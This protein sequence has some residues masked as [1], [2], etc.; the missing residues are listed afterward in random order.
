M[1]RLFPKS[2]ERCG[3][4]WPWNC[5]YPALNASTWVTG[6][7]RRAMR[8]LHGSWKLS[9]RLITQSFT[10][11]YFYL[12]W[13][14][15]CFAPSHKAPFPVLSRNV[16]RFPFPTALYVSEQTG[17]ALPTCPR[18]R[19]RTVPIPPHRAPHSR[20]VPGRCPTRGA[21]P[22]GA[23][24]LL[25]GTRCRLELRPPRNHRRKESPLPADGQRSRARGGSCRCRGRCTGA[26]AAGRAEG[27]GL[28]RVRRSL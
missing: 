23:A 6:R 17:R 16:P 15:F 13:F 3:C 25:R 9:S 7:A 24:R 2:M 5:A 8:A 10:H 11:F 12:F 27:D 21:A 14:C 4:C 28:L 26:G 20:P 22:P 18:Q 1:P 19:P